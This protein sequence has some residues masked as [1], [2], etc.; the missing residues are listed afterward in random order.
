V[1]K[2]KAKMEIEEGKTLKTILSEEEIDKIP[3]DLQSKIESVYAKKFEDF[4]VQKSLSETARNS[5]GRT[6]W[7]CVFSEYFLRQLYISAFLRL[8]E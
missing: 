6:C 5:I 2:I 8:T 1:A 3:P 4:L 7:F